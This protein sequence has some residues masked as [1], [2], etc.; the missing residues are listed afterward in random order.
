VYP[1][2]APASRHVA[3]T[4]RDDVVARIVERE[5]ERRARSAVDSRNHCEMGISSMS[6]N[7]CTTRDDPLDS[8]CAGTAE[9]SREV[10]SPSFRRKKFL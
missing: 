10:E 5:R 6:E 1:L 2:G 8:A 3:T 9:R 7:S 4:R